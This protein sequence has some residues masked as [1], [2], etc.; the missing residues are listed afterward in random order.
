LQGLIDKASSWDSDLGSDMLEHVVEAWRETVEK[1]RPRVMGG[2]MKLIESISDLAY[3]FLRPHLDVLGN[4]FDC[5][6]GHASDNNSLR[7][8]LG[9]VFGGWYD[10]DASNG[11]VGATAVFALGKVMAEREAG[12]F[13]EPHDEP[14]CCLESGGEA[15]DGGEDHLGG[16]ESISIVHIHDRS[17]AHRA[18]FRVKR[19]DFRVDCAAECSGSITSTLPCAFRRIAAVVASE[20]SF[21]ARADQERG[22][23]GIA[24]VEQRDD[25]AEALHLRKAMHHN[26]SIGLI[27]AVP[28]IE[29]NHDMRRVELEV[30]TDAVREDIKAAG[31]ADS[32]LL[33]LKVLGS[34]GCHFT[35]HH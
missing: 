27:V 16:S 30:E 3:Y 5:A 14:C 2:G 23:G 9:A 21:A 15:L 34:G 33:R 32:N 19:L 10:D 35:V 13:V 12:K 7:P 26:T 8:V 22:F 24:C 31:D 29:L 18:K 11:H 20:E 1:S 4:K 6:Y 28:H 25:V 17:P